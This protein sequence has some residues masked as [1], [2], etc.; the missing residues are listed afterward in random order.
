MKVL[1]VSA[2][3]KEIEPLFKTLGVQ[4][5][6]QVCYYQGLDFNNK[7]ID[8]LITGVGMVS[9]T[10]WA[11]K[12]LHES[13]YNIA[14]NIGIAGCFDYNYKLGE[15]VNVVSDTFSELGAETEDGFD[16]IFDIGLISSEEGPYKNGVLKNPLSSF[17][18]LNELPQ[19]CAITANTIHGKEDS[20]NKLKDYYNPDIET[21]EGGAFAFCCLMDNIDFVQIRG[22]SNYVE[23]RDPSKWKIDLA[24]ENANK[25]LEEFLND[26]EGL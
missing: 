18:V 25:I 24:I 9:T 21:M 23:K 2:T 14:I 10:Y 3:Y 8:I 11:S 20:I 4:Y 26:K 16:S 22:I 19:V 1:V 13:T 5:I 17:G 7:S 6:P 12:I 15:V